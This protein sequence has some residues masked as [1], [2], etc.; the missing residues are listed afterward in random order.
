MSKFVVQSRLRVTSLPFV[1]FPTSDYPS[2]FYKVK[3]RINADRIVTL[4]GLKIH[5]MSR[6]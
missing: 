6:Y 3:S 5:V 2:F 4:L 1:D